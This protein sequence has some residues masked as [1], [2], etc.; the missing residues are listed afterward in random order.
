MKVDYLNAMGETLSAYID[1]KRAVVRFGEASGYIGYRLWV[2]DNIFTNY[3]KFDRHSN[4]TEEEL[5]KLREIVNNTR[6]GLA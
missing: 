4:F 1:L 6:K 3:I 2:Y 5:R